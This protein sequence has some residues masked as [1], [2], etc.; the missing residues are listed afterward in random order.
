VVLPIGDAPNPR[1]VP[2][3]TY[4]IIAINVA[5]YAF[6]TLPLSDQRPLP[7]D[8]ALAEYLRVMG[9]VLGRQVPMATFA[10][11]VSAYDLYVFAHAFRPAAPTASGFV[12]SMFLHGGFLH[13]FGN[14]LFLWIY[15]DNVERR[16]GPLRYALAYL[17]TGSA[18]TLFHWAGAP[19][20]QVPVVGASGAISGV[21]GLYFVWFPRNVVRMLWL[22]PPFLGNVFEVPAR[23]V[24]GFYL[25]FDNLLPYLFAGDDVGVAHGAH[26]GGFIAGVAIAW[27]ADRY[28]IVHRP[29]EYADAVPESPEAVGALVDESR[30][31]DAAAAYF[32]Q[33]AGATRGR[34]SPDRGFELAR[35]LRA[36]GHLDAVLVLLRRMVRDLP[37]GR[38]R[39]AAHLEL[40]S[41]LLD[42]AGQPTPAYQ[43]FL[44]VLDEDA[45]PATQARARVALQQ[46]AGLQ[47]RRRRGAE[48][49]G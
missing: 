41:I 49:L 45:D 34:L 37:P 18:A 44:A 8:P 5:I 25:V 4:A 33:S 15:G 29:S 11:Q 46:I 26:I 24:L 27:V 1:G 28:G 48:P 10:Q 40:G 30:F 38:D 47:K 14:M 20:S 36:N 7:G 12:L 22:L 2:V 21:L 19:A 35:W 23:V 31:A 32:R 16:M 17:G 3:V 43:H 39:A 13:L 9:R 42:D 6:L